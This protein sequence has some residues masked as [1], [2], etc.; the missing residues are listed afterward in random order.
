VLVVVDAVGFG[1]AKLASLPWCWTSV[2]IV[3]FEAA[4]TALVPAGGGFGGR[5]ISGAGLATVLYRRMHAGRL[6]PS[7]F[8]VLT[9]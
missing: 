8:L 5:F 9:I 2:T 1:G 7:P 4:T 6:T 3:A